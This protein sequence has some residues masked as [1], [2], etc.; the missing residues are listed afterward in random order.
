MLCDLCHNHIATVHLTEII[1]E[2]VTELHICQGCAKSK[3]EELKQQLNISDFVG[4]LIPG[5]QNREKDTNLKCSCCGISF[6]DFKKKGRLG[7]ANCYVAF[8]A[9]L[10][11]LIKKIHGSVHHRGKFPHHVGEDLVIGEKV[12][13]LKARLERAIQL[14]EY[15]EAANLRDQIRELE[16]GVKSK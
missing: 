4:G 7:C 2:K 12:K 10:V 9:Q 5:G 13:V 16:K 8:K 14:E 6:Y 1:D 15:E 11:P 3:T